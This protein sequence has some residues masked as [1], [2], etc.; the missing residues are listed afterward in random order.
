MRLDDYDPNSDI[1][2][3]GTG[4]GGFSGGFGGGGLGSLI[5]FLPLLLICLF[6]AKTPSRIWQVCV[7]NTMPWFR[8]PTVNRNRWPHST[9]SPGFAHSLR[10]CWLSAMVGVVFAHYWNN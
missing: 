8:V 9:Q 10:R 3:M 5:G 7:L 4:G 1:Q 6:L 2:D